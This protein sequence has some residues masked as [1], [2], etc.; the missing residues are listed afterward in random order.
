M[1]AELPYWGVERV[2]E[3]RV[4]G[5]DTMVLFL[6]LILQ[7][8]RYKREREEKCEV[9]RCWLAEKVTLADGS[10]KLILLLFSFNHSWPLRPCPL[11]FV[12]VLLS[13]PP[14]FIH[15][16]PPPFFSLFIQSPRKCLRHFCLEKEKSHTALVYLDA[17][18]FNF[19]SQQLKTL[20]FVF[21]AKYS[22]YRDVYLIRSP[23]K[24]LGLTIYGLQPAFCC[25][26][27]RFVVSR[28]PK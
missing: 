27:S 15:H 20:C 17:K 7:F 14:S 2:K 4:E 12:P 18:S 25:I 5:M 26:V 9:T 21:G 23:P 1:L 19:G 24:F 10:G 6:K 8:L 28:G 22:F 11:H 3:I 16:P 13:W